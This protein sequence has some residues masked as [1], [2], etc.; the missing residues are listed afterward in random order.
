MFAGWPNAKQGIPMAHGALPSRET[1]RQFEYY[2]HTR[3]HFFFLGSGVRNISEIIINTNK[4][5]NGIKL[6]SK[7][8]DDMQFT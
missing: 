1:A 2:P 5:L 4:L 3:L 8:L 6:C 7:K